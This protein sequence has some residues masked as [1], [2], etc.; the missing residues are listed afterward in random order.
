[1]ATINLAVELLGSLEITPEDAPEIDPVKLL[2]NQRAALRELSYSSWQTVRGCPRRYELRKFTKY[3]RTDTIDTLFGKAVGIGVQTLIASGGDMAKAMFAAWLEWPY[4][5]YTFE[6]QKKKKSLWYALHALKK[7]P[8]FLQADY[9]IAMIGGV[10][11]CELG[12][13]ISLPDGFYYRGFIDTVLRRK[14]DG[15]LTVLELKTTGMR[16]VDDAMYENSEQGIGY[17]I[18]LDQIDPEATNYDVLYMIYLSTSMEF[19]PRP[20]PK[21]KLAR[22][23]WLQAL[24]MQTRIIQMYE[25]EGM[26]PKNGDSCYGYSRQCQFF[27]MCDMSNEA[28]GATAAHYKPEA[29]DKYGI[30]VEFMDILD[31]ELSN[32]TDTAG[33]E[34]GS[35]H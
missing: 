22:A 13:K 12:I 2:A 33:E 16:Y 29:D 19:D 20:Y 14:S 9:E 35:S 25:A 1:M 31:S 30:K 5:E 26:F 15:K 17:S 8:A 4:K 28:L 10:P 3:A 27:R 11:A 34:D 6:D 32:I 23:N 24:L 21:T 18:A 7:V